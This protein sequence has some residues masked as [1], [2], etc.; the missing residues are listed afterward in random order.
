M[1]YL[2]KIDSILLWYRAFMQ[3]RHPKEENA[4]D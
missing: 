1:T 4:A 3:I 2:E